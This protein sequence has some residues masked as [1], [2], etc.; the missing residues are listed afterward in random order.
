MKIEIGDDFDD[1]TLIDISDGFDCETGVGWYGY[2]SDKRWA[3][4]VTTKRG[5][6]DLLFRSKERQLEMYNKIKKLTDW[7]AIDDFI[8]SV[9]ELDKAAENALESMKPIVR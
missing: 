3:V 1:Y 5:T 2:E 8:A 6:Y 4:N 9:E 7:S